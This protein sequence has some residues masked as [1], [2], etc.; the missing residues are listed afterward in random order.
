MRMSIRGGNLLVSKRREAASDTTE[1]SIL[2][3]LRHQVDS[4]GGLDP[5]GGKC[6][7]IIG[8]RWTM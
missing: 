5:V 6:R 3:N 7:R 8:S 2:L 4:A 1:M